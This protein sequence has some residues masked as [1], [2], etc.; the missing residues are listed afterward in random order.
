[1]WDNQVNIRYTQKNSCLW[2]DTY[3]PKSEKLEWL[4]PERLFMDSDY[5][6][7]DELIDENG[8]VENYEWSVGVRFYLI[9]FTY[10]IDYTLFHSFD[11]PYDE[12]KK[13]LCYFFF[14]KKRKL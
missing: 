8:W 5:K 2:T 12:E 9:M 11:L 14:L 1:M 13:G 7:A 6:R 10:R 4:M 3:L